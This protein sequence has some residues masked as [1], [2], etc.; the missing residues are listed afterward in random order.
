M[1]N[2]GHNF[3]DQELYINFPAIPESGRKDH[4]ELTFSYFNIGSE[5]KRIFNRVIILKDLEYDLV[6]I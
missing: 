5:N 1:H 6:E 4:N 2:F 3:I